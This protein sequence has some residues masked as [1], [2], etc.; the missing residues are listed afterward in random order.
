MELVGKGVDTKADGSDNS[1]LTT[2]ISKTLIITHNMNESNNTNITVTDGEDRIGWKGSAMRTW[3][4]GTLKSAIPEIVRN[5]IKPVNKTQS[6]WSGSALVKDGQTTED[7]VWI[8]SNHEIFNDSAYETQG[9][10]YTL[11]TK[12]KLYNSSADIWW[13]RSASS[14]SYFRFVNSY[15]NASSNYANI[16]SGVAL[17][18]C[19]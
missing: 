17:G 15:G 11:G 13:L 1:T 19:L 2:W 14:T 7:D 9:P 18:F 6:I 3:L 8:P 12:I 16:T 4:Q 10:V 5:A